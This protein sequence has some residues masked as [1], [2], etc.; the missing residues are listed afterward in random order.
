MPSIR[1][2]NFC[3]VLLAVVQKC[4]VMHMTTCGS[5]LYIVTTF[6]STHDTRRFTM[7]DKSIVCCICAFTRYG[8]GRFDVKRTKCPPLF[9]IIHIQHVHSTRIGL[10]KI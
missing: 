5:T 9:R 10:C 8:R 7:S 2:A 6:C 3:F 4:S 1:S